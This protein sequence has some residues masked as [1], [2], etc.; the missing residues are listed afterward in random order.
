MAKNVFLNEN[1]V[2][3]IDKLVVDAESGR[4]IVNYGKENFLLGA[5]SAA[6]F[7]ATGYCV[8]EAVKFGVTVVK[9]L[10]S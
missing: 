6:A 7:A 3:V 9:Y 1:N 2:K 10:K 8:Y 5:A 4:A